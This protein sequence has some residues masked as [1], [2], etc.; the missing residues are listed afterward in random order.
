MLTD[1]VKEQLVNIGVDVMLDQ[2]AQ[3]DHPLARV[4]WAKLYGAMFNRED[5]AE[6]VFNA[7]DEYVEE[8]SK[9]ENS[10]KSLEVCRH[11]LRFS[12]F[13]PDGCRLG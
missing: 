7:Q 11:H 1:D 9:L 5:D 8:L 4:E 3:E 6:D 2:S 13:Y 10:G 12:Q